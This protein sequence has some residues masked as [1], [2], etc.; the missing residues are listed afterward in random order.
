MNLPTVKPVYFARRINEEDKE[1][2]DTQIAQNE[3]MLNENFTEM[4][5]TLAELI[6][7]YNEALARIKVLEG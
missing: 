4:N 3:Q 1:T 5:L 2:Q 7:G 6:D